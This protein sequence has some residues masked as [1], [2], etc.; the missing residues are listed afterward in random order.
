MNAV[1]LR[2]VAVENRIADVSLTLAPGTLA[3]L[4]GPNGAGKSTV[5][6]VVA[7]LLPT[8][9]RVTWSGRELRTIPVL[10]RGRVAA[11]VPQEARFEFGFTVRAVVA[12]ARYAHG[13]DDLG[14]DAALERFELTALAQ[15]PVNRL[16]GGER[17]RVLLARA[18]ATDAPLQFWDEPLAA[19]DPRHGLQLI[20]LARQ[21]VRAGKTILLSLHDLRLAHSLD[22]V[23]V[24]AGGRLRA[25]GAPRD[26]MTPDLLQDVFGVKAR[27]APGLTFEL[28]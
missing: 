25:F 7:G 15:R 4:V 6:Q 13:D 8:S 19:L 20:Q 23:A 9:G 17:Q 27:T 26:V 14:V 2:Q 3:G 11:W 18:V 28:P 22:Q 5:L 24:M 10:E 21:M 16:S 12:Q 1:E